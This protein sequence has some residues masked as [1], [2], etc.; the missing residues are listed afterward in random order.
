MNLVIGNTYQSARGFGVMTYIGETPGIDGY[1]PTFRKKDGGLKAYNH[2]QLASV[3]V[4]HDEPKKALTG[5]LRE[6]ILQLIAETLTIDVV[7]RSEYIGD[8]DGSGSLYKDS[9]TLRVL[10]EGEVIS[11]VYL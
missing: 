3:L 8:M 4:G 6:A 2:N 7:T 11:E 9:H 10:L 5:G 1:L